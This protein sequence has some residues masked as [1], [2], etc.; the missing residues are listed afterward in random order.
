MIRRRPKTDFKGTQG[1]EKWQIAVH[2]IVSAL[3]NNS[4][5][6]SATDHKAPKYAGHPLY[7][8]NLWDNIYFRLAKLVAMLNIINF[9]TKHVL[10][11]FLMYNYQSIETTL[12]HNQMCLTTHN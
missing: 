2:C 12:E 9:Y 8:Q 3:R 1:P 7:A 6:D 11:F 5:T 10:L 4:H